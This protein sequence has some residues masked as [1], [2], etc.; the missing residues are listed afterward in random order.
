M[1][2]ERLQAGTADVSSAPCP[3]H[4]GSLPALQRG[5]GRMPAVQPS[6]QS[7]D[8]PLRAAVLTV[9]LL[10]ACQ[11]QP[12]ARAQ[13]AALLSRE[14]PAARAALARRLT[15][16]PVPGQVRLLGRQVVALGISRDQW[17]MG[18]GPAAVAVHNT[19]KRPMSPPLVLA[20]N[21]AVE[22]EPVKATI[23]D[24]QRP[25]VL[26]FRGSAT[27]RPV[28]SA[29]PPGGRRLYTITTNRTWQPGVHDRRPLGVRVGLS[30]AD[31]LARAVGQH[32]LLAELATERSLQRQP[33]LGHRVVGLG[34]GPGRWADDGRTA[35]VLL[36]QP[37][38]SR[39]PLAV[40]LKLS[41]RGAAA[42]TVTV[43]EGDTTRQLAL[44]AGQQRS[45]A[46]SPLAPGQ[47]RLALLSTDRGS[48]LGAGST[49]ASGV[50]VR[51]TLVGLLEPL[52]QGA[53][54][55][56]YR[57]LLARAI[58][59]GRLPGVRQLA[60]G[61]AVTVGLTADRWTTPGRPA[62][63]VL[64]NRE[65]RPARW[66]LTLASQGPL[67][68]TVNDGWRT[69]TV[70]LAAAGQRQLKLAVVPAFTRRL[71][72]IS[73]AAGEVQLVGLQRAR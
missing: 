3:P 41:L 26:V 55:P 27:L 13:L 22:G 5:A 30:L 58:R 40:T 46:L 56:I 62:A 67:S 49:R 6:S 37:R 68:I 38:R 23:H 10:S 71:V 33:L 50:Q 69:Q 39:W 57:S 16:T 65:P 8:H 36:S 53:R 32:H 12:D 63:L 64:E 42:V 72:V 45:L 15:S 31:V 18:L 48:L 7:P 54:D 66:T 70:Q 9:L 52:L 73:A 44:S 34:L 29:I 2:V 19:S 21:P 47:R 24:G 14:E 4:Q 60:G 59:A 35:G 11:Q 25:Q 17:T 20:S 28:L 61:P 51:L 43:T 1:R